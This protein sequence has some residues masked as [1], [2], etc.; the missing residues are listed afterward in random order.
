VSN[1]LVDTSVS[2]ALL[3][4]HIM[5][6]AVSRILSRQDPQQRQELEETLAYAIDCCAG[7]QLPA[8]TLGVAKI[9]TIWMDSVA[10]KGAPKLDS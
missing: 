6:P 10:A 2:E 9:L 5:M 8:G 7:G 4:L 3:A 1:K